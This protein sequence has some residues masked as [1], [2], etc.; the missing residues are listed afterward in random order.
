MNYEFNG[1]DHP[2]HLE[3][4]PE[5]IGPSSTWQ[6]GPKYLANPISEWPFE[7]NFT[8]Q[9]STVKLPEVEIIKEHGG[10]ARPD[11]YCSPSSIHQA[12]MQKMMA[13]SSFLEKRDNWV[14]MQMK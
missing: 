12:I 7:R 5:D 8:N 10:T 9:K 11:A 6:N 3:T 2:I 13:K 1:A 4:Q 14:T